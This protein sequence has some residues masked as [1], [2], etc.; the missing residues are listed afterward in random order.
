MPQSRPLRRLLARMYLDE[1][2]VTAAQP[3]KRIQRL[4]D[5]RA[6]APSAARTACQGN[7]RRLPRPERGR[8]DRPETLRQLRR[9]VDY[10]IG[11]NVFDQAARRQ[12]VSGPARS[13]RFSN[14][15]ESV[16][17]VRGQTRSPPASPTANPGSPPPA[18]A[19]SSAGSV[20]AERRQ[21]PDRRR[22]PPRKPPVPPAAQG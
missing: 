22:S 16:H 20:M 19:A 4:D 2:A 17:A 3:R 12:P 5:A 11:C 1:A 10:L 14:R 13:D 6:L 15:R 8:A 18:S 7:H 21:E 9:C